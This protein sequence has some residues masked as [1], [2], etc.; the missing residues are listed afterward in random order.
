LDENGKPVSTINECIHQ[1]VVSRYAKPAQLCSDDAK[2]TCSV[3]PY[4]PETLAPFF[5]GGVFAGL[6]V[7]V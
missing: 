1:S 3:A 4:N 7:V 2:G 5:N 6:P